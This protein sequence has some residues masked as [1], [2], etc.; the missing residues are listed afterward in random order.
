MRDAR[1]PKPGMPKDNRPPREPK[2]YT[3]MIHLPYDE[4][5]DTVQTLPL[6]QELGKLVLEHPE[7]MTDLDTHQ[8]KFDL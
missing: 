3:D 5:V 8:I 1:N 6:E 4:Q 7:G 2:F